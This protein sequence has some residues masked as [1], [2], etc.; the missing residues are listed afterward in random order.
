MTQMTQTSWTAAND[1]DDA[2][3]IRS[4]VPETEAIT[5]GWAPQA[6]QFRKS[7]PHS[8]LGLAY[9][10]DPR[11]K[12]DLFLPEG[13][14][15]GLMVFTHGGYWVAFDNSWWSHLAAGMLAHG[16]AVALSN[17]RL[18]IQ[19]SMEELAGDVAAAITLAGEQVAGPIVLTGHSAGGHLTALMASSGLLAAPLRERLA[20]VMPISGLFDLRPLLQTA[21]NKDLKMT[22]ASAAALSPLLLAPQGDFDLLCVVGA[23]ERP[24]FLRQNAMLAPVWAGLGIDGRA[25]EL[26]GLH[27]FDVIDGLA[28][29]DS[30]M[31]R[32]LAGR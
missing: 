22:A 29:P 12:I 9:G 4:Y 17:Y 2:F 16:W 10:D 28:D 23:D 5:E 19:V 7:W 31:C 27:H 21:R 26:A 24:E 20:R 15:Q 1:M 8:K 30:L 6:Q 3:E 18:A 11:Q 14:P 13:E 25:V 32:F